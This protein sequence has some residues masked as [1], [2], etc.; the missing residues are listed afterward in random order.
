MTMRILALDVRQE[1]DVVL[2]RQ[3]A[4]QIAA[5]LGFP[6]LDQTRIAT[7]TSEI[8]RNALHY[9]GGGTAEFLVEPTVPQSLE[10]LV[11]QR[12]PG[13]DSM[14]AILDGEPVSPTGAG[15][16][17]LG[18]RRLMDRFEI[19]TAPGAGV[20]VRMA[21]NLPRRTVDLSPRELARISDELSR[22]APQ[23]LL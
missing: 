10:V 21:K 17:I 16:G 14:Q 1:G 19:V 3:R 2:A 4:R 22:H 18:A 20:A 8:A 23:G 5:L 13:I 12:G 11:T 7:A 15:L 9:A 6:P